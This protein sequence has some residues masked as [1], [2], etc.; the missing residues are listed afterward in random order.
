ML[1][2]G[3][4]GMECV[5]SVLCYKGIILQKKM[6]IFLSLLCEI[7]FKKNWEPQLHL[8]YPN[9]CYIKVYY[10]ETAL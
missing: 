7:P 9:Q 5:I 2:L 6:V 4:I 3:S 1:C 10:E 8:F